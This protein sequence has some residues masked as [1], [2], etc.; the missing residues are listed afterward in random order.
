M[1]PQNCIIKWTEHNY[2]F[3]NGLLKEIEVN[4]NSI[5][6]GLSIKLKKMQTSWNK[7]IDEMKR[8]RD[9]NDSGLEAERN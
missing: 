5:C 1:E 3:E 6:F 8:K 2:T 7:N 9:E 4:S